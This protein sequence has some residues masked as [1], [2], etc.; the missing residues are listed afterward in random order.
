[1]FS[2]LK[3]L[4]RAKY[5]REAHE[6]DFG[7]KAPIALAR[8]SEAA[9]YSAFRRFVMTNPCACCVV[10]L[11]PSVCD[12]NGGFTA[13][14]RRVVMSKTFA[15]MYDDKILC[16][17]VSN[18]HPLGPVVPVNGKRM[19]FD[20]EIVLLDRNLYERGSVWRK[21]SIQLTRFWF[22]SGMSASGPARASYCQGFVFSGR[23]ETKSNAGDFQS[24]VSPP[25]NAVSRP[26]RNHRTNL[27]KD[28]LDGPLFLPRSMRIPPISLV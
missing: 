18:S 2:P 14:V 1:M 26:I 4:F 10:V 11:E 3:V 17:A 20:R 28:D 12:L 7:I 9:N 25:P 16:T 13:D 24:A 15:T 27:I 6:Q 23:A 19:T 8:K 21:H 5:S 22:S